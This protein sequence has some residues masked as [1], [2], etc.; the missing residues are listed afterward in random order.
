MN[1]IH[2]R[3]L[4]I[5][6]CTIDENDT[7]V[8]RTLYHVSIGDDITV[9]RYEDTGTYTLNFTPQ[10]QTEQV[11]KQIIKKRISTYDHR[12]QHINADDRRFNNPDSFCDG[13]VSCIHE[14]CVCNY[15]VFQIYPLYIVRLCKLRWVIFSY[16]II[17]QLYKTYIYNHNQ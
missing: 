6:F 7:N 11:T 10:R 12:F 3:N 13:I 8:S 16:L 4:S 17:V 5:K 2:T 1:G 9:C 14:V 15:S